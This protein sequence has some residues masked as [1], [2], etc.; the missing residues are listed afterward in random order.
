MLIATHNAET[1]SAAVDAVW[2]AMVSEEGEWADAAPRILGGLMR[3]L[4]EETAK[5]AAAHF[6]FRFA[7]A[8]SSDEEH[9][10][11]LDGAIQEINSEGNCLLEILHGKKSFEF[12]CC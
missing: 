11:D 4:D 12:D 3:A 9:K 2:R 7:V 6:L 8:S 5:K 1:A 10:E